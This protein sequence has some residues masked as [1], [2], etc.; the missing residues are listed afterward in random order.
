MEWS[1]FRTEYLAY[2]RAA[3]ADNTYH[4]DR[5]AIESLEQFLK[6]TTLE[7]ITARTI[8]FWRNQRVGKKPATLNRDLKAIKAMLHKAKCWGYL[9]E[10]FWKEVPHIKETRGRLLYY[11]VDDFNR[12]LSECN[13]R[14]PNL[15]RNHG[16]PYNWRTVAM[17][18]ARAGLR[19]SE[20]RYLSWVDIDFERGI[21]SVTPKDDWHPKD[22]EPRYIP[23]SDDLREHLRGLPRDSEWILSP[24]PSL[25]VMSSYFKRIVNRA[26]LKGGIHT[27]RHTFASH[28]VQN[29]VPIYDVSK[30]LGHADVTMTQVY[31][32][33]APNNLAAAIGKLPSLNGA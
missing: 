2:S 6:L 14:F 10:E 3:K 11:S 32:H 20:I 9:K 7:E 12:I 22:F 18:A 5:R 25:E 17:L 24:R 13:C 4:R 33:L 28:L 27:L 26:G 21:I 8:E 31:A 1:T 29:G 30:L 23:M 19:R 16:R 15:V